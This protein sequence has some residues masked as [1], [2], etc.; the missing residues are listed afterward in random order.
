MVCFVISF[1]FPKFF[2]I[3]KLFLLILLTFLFLDIIILYATR[4]G[5]TG[6]RETPEKFSNGDENPIL[7]EIQNY[8]TFPV[9]ANIIDEIPEQFQV[10]DFSIIKKIPASSAIALKYKLR[11]TERGEY[12]FGKLNVYFIGVRIGFQTFSL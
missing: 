12:T 2:F 5:I 1:I 9:Q 8:Y 3:T 6:K 10:R 11:P 4:V 7:I